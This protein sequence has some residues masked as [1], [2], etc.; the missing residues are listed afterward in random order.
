[1]CSGGIHH[2]IIRCT[3]GFGDGAVSHIH[4]QAVEPQ[5]GCQALHRIGTTAV[6]SGVCR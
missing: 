6:I 5:I 1:M 4:G 2:C 3:D